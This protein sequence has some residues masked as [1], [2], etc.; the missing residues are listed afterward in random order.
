MRCAAARCVAL[1]PRCGAQSGEWGPGP[2]CKETGRELGFSY[3]L[4]NF[5]YCGIEVRRAAH[6]RPAN[7]R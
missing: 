2:T 5:L 6:A 1:T 3:G 7:P 4:D